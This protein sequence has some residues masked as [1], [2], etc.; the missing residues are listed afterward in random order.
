MSREYNIDFHSVGRLGI[1]GAKIIKSRKCLADKRV[2]TKSFSITLFLFTGR[3]IS[4]S[5]EN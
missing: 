2:T 1:V 3:D 5:L 4:L